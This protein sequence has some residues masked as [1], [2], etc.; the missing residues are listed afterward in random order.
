MKNLKNILAVFG[1]ITIFAISMVGAFYKNP[2]DIGYQYVQ[3]MAQVVG[4]SSQTFLLTA[5]GVVGQMSGG[6]VYQ[7]Q[8]INPRPITADE[9]SQLKFSIYRVTNTSAPMQQIIAGAQIGNAYNLPINDSKN[10]EDHYELSIISIPSGMDHCFSISGSN[11]RVLQ[12]SNLNIQIQCVDKYIYIDSGKSSAE[13]Y[14]PPAD[15][16][17]DT[18]ESSL[19]SLSYQSLP[20]DLSAGN[21]NIISVKKYSLKNKNYLLVLTDGPSLYVFNEDNPYSPKLILKN[22]LKNYGDNLLTVNNYPNIVV[23]KDLYSFSPTSGKINF[24]S[25]NNIFS[26]TQMLF[27]NNNRTYA[28]ATSATSTKKNSYLSL[29]FYDVTNPLSIKNT[30]EI[31]IGQKCFGNSY[32][33]AYTG[34]NGFDPNSTGGLLDR[35][36]QDYDF[37]LGYQNEWSIFYVGTKQYIAFPLIEFYHALRNGHGQE[38]AVVDITNPSNPQKVFIVDDQYFVSSQSAILTANGIFSHP[39][40]YPII[41]SV[42]KKIAI[43]YQTIQSEL[44]PPTASY[45]PE[46]ASAMTTKGILDTGISVLSFDS[47]LVKPISQSDESAPFEA[48]PSFSEIGSYLTCEQRGMS[49]VSGGGTQANY[50]GSFNSYRG[51]NSSL[52]SFL[53]G[54]MYQNIYTSKYEGGLQKVYNKS[55]LSFMGTGQAFVWISDPSNQLVEYKNHL[56]K[57]YGQIPIIGAVLDQTDSKN[58]A[59]VQYDSKHMDVVRASFNLD[60]QKQSDN[61]S[62]NYNQTITNQ[63]PSVNTSI[64]SFTNLLNIFKNIMGK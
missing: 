41:D 19:A 29:D 9:I 49:D 43:Y 63:N 22:N 48:S 36:Y 33:Y 15:N 61:N 51:K 39:Q 5:Y 56:K 28:A 47:G 25:S 3:L 38:L 16:Q 64:F 1:G 6:N 20:L 32:N 37:N 44:V 59:V 23:G 18:T 40:F 34:I 11:I 42:N 13:S 62:N 26:E 2:V 54:L 8:V 55:E 35:C 14:N 31:L 30:G 27:N 24:V 50:C 45:S 17:V 21:E 4:S 46:M 53:N 7:T 10:Y 52:I 12:S 57:N 58:F 60:I